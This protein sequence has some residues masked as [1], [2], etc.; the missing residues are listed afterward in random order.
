MEGGLFAASPKRKKFS[1]FGR[2]RTKVVIV[3]TVQCGDTSTRTLVFFPNMPND[4]EP[5]SSSGGGIVVS[6]MNSEVIEVN[7]L[8]TRPNSAGLFQPW[9]MNRT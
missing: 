1:R 8:S 6:S 7:V 3:A 2:E 9:N 4:T 5:G